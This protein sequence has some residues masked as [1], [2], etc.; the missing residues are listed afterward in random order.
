MEM[1]WRNNKK[2]TSGLCKNI[3]M[4]QIMCEAIGGMSD[5]VSDW[6]K[7]INKWILSS[8]QFIFRC[9]AKK[10]RKRGFGLIK[11]TVNSTNHSLSLS[12]FQ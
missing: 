2:K 7:E 8:A 3:E 4:I 1:D 11:I 5:W 12:A 9:V 10:R 6:V